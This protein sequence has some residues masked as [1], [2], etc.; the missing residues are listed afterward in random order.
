MKRDIT[1]ETMEIQKHHQ[2]LLP[3]LILNK[4]GKSG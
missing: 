2:I 1:M 3:K 4:I